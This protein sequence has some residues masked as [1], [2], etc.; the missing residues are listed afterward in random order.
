MAEELNDDQRQLDELNEMWT[1][2]ELSTAQYRKMRKGI[3]DRIAKAQHKVVI[4]PMVL[5]TG[6]R[7][8]VHGPLGRPRT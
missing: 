2:K 5:S 4:R 6:S 7:V 8:R 3:T 1:A